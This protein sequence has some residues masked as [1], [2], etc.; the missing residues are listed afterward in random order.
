LLGGGL[1]LM[2]CILAYGP[3]LHGKFLWD[4]LYLV[5]TNPFFRSPRFVLEVFRH[6]LFLD[7]FSV[8]YRPVQNLSYIVDYAIWNREEFGYHLSNILFHAASAFLLCLVVRRILKSLGTKPEE[9]RME[10]FADG[11]GFCG[12]AVAVH[13]IHNAA[14]AYVAGR[15]D[16][17]AMMFALAGWL[18][19]LNERRGGAG[20]LRWR[21]RQC[22]C[23]R[24][25]ARRR[26]R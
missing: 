18:L 23:W 7:S 20:L 2:A 25:C 3:V 4:D 15:A 21:W 26:L 24:R 5:G 17:I 1:I 9:G 19:F 11:A 6:Y 8:Y 22:A 14:V 16:S 13:P 12:A 10:G